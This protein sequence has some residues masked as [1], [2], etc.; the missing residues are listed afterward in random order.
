MLLRGAA[1][2]FWG[3]EV[4]RGQTGDRDPLPLTLGFGW[5]W[6]GTARSQE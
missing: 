1:G 5:P 3:G 6:R 2:S 4:E